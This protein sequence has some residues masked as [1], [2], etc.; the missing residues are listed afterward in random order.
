MKTTLA[1]AFAAVAIASSA[2]TAAALAPSGMP[3]PAAVSLTAAASTATCKHTY[4]ELFMSQVIQFQWLIVS[5]YPPHRDWLPYMPT[6]AQR[7]HERL[8]L[9]QLNWFMSNGPGSSGPPVIKC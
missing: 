5:H 6:S 7:H 4:A 1:A 8:L 9:D 2:G 3:P